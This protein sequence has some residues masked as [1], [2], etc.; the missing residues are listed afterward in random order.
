MAKPAGNVACRSHGHG[1]VHPERRMGLLWAWT[2]ALNPSQGV[3]GLSVV[4]SSLMF[5]AGNLRAR[6]LKVVIM[7]KAVLSA[8]S[9]SVTRNE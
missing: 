5:P 2:M 9:C 3:G 1:F 6:S 4:G 8:G 7:G